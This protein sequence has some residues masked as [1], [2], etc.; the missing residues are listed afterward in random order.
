MRNT[1][2]A[3][4]GTL[5]LLASASAFG[6]QTV[7]ADVPFEFS[8]ANKVMPAGQYDIT[9]TAGQLLVRCYSARAA[10]FAQ[11]N[12]LGGGPG[13]NAPS[14]LTFNKYGDKYFLAEVW[15]SPRSGYGA[16]LN[17]SKT[18]REIARITQHVARISIP[19]R[20]GVATLAALR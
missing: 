9:H 3:A 18:E 8:I 17:K 20:A 7:R 15:W 1:T 13:E 16:G 10:A 14:R 4:L 6:Q 11:A 2:L 5:A 12:N 19:A